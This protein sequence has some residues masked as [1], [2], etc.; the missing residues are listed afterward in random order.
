M[1]IEQPVTRPC[2]LRDGVRGSWR[3][4]WRRRSSGHGATGGVGSVAVA[5]LAKLGYKVWLRQRRLS[6]EGTS[7]PRYHRSLIG[8]AIATG[9]TFRKER[10]AGVLRRRELPT[11][12]NAGAT[13]YGG[14]GGGLWPRARYGLP[15]TVMPFILP[16]VTLVGVDSVIAPIAFTSNELGPLG[17]RS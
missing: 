16:G 2:F 12:A 10:W 4:T 11:L 13:R 15:T 6:E 9:Q 7:N 17:A 1:A 5:L 8:R 3:S 14:I